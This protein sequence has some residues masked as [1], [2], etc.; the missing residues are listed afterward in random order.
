MEILIDIKGSGILD[1]YVSNES[2]FLKQNGFNLK[3]LSKFLR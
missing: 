1:Y 3:T 2:N